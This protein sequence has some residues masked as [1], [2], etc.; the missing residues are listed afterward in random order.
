MQHTQDYLDR[1]GITELNPMQQDVLAQRD[2]HRDQ[3]LLSPTGSG[4]TLAFTLLMLANHPLG[5]SKTISHLVVAPTRELAAQI[6]AVIKRLQ[7]GFRVICLHGGKSTRMEREDLKRNAQIIVATPGR[8]C[9]HIEHSADLLAD[10]QVLVIDEFDKCLELGFEE[11]LGQII[12]A[13]NSSAQH[14]LTSATNLDPMPSFLPLKH[15]KTLNY[16]DDTAVQP[17]HQTYSIEAPSSL[18]L[19]MLFKLLCRIGNERVLVFCNHRDTTDHVASLLERKGIRAQIYHGG[20]EQWERQLALTKLRNGTV[21]ILITTDLAARGLD[22]EGVHHV[23]HYQWPV[24]VEDYLHRNG[25]SGR[26]GEVGSIYGFIEKP[27]T[28]PEFFKETAVPLLLDAYYPVPQLP[29]FCTLRINAGKKQKI[30]KVDI[31][32][33]FLKQ[34]GA[35]KDDLGMI[36]VGSDEAFVAVR[37]GLANQ[38]ANPVND[39]RIKKAKVRIRLV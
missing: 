30:N 17:T 24:K 15:T 19:E 14:V 18:K 34:D 27:G 2:A 4:K 38:W 16:L 13:S 9:Y 33:F 20:M 21:E 28:A 3:I 5:P 31:V 11:Q 23:I 29:A 39:A 37:R 36:S 32:G 22:V 7:T 1:L 35:Q 26:H 8:L 6:D 10:L 25:R 12:A